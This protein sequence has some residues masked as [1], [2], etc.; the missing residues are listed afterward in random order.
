M[1]WLEVL[2]IPLVLG[3]ASS[4]HCIGMCGVFAVRAHSGQTLLGF[5]LYLIG[6]SFSYAF[7]GAIAGWLGSQIIDD[8]TLWRAYA[9]LMAG[10]VL[11]LAGASSLFVS[12]SKSTLSKQITAWLAPLMN[13]ARKE[14]GKLGT[15]SLGA[16]TG[17]LPCGVVYIGAAQAMVAKNIAQAVV[18]MVVLSLSTAPA[19]FA[20]AYF[21][22]RFERRLSP[23]L[24][25]TAGPC[26]LVLMGCFSI[27]RAMGP[28]L[29]EPGAATCCH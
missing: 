9:A 23:R 24:L 7:I 22:G 2:T 17:L 13:L 25:R 26:L 11:I 27:W 5:P 6:K 21:S 3:L 4:A 8:S 20:I 16:L 10:A 29:A 1:T 15:F 19:L 14:G 28:I 12:N 18:M